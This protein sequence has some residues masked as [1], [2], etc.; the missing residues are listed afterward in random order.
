MPRGKKKNQEE[1]RIFT[2]EGP[3]TVDLSTSEHPDF[4]VGLT[5]AET[6]DGAILTRLE[7][8]DSADVCS[9]VNYD[10]DEY[11]C[12]VHEPKV[13]CPKCCSVGD[14]RKLRSDEDAFLRFSCKVCG[15]FYVRNTEDGQYLYHE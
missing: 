3:K 5:E 15:A 8:V 11:F 7:V 10:G 12:K 4:I 9:C 14:E 1:A 6:R 13:E 2:A